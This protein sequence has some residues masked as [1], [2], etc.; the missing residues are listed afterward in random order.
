MLRLAPAPFSLFYRPQ[1]T[2][3]DESGVEIDSDFMPIVREVLGRRMPQVMERAAELQRRAEAAA[4][5]G[6]EQQQQQQEEGQSGAAEGQSG[7]AEGQSGAAE[8]QPGA[9]EGQPGP[10][11]N[12]KLD[13]ETLRMVSRVVMGRLDVVDL[14]GRNTA[15]ELAERVRGREGGG[16]GRGA[17]DAARRGGAPGWGGPGG[18]RRCGAGLP[19]RAMCMR[20]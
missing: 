11:D 4:A 19:L 8:G 2:P 1:S 14:V 16:A 17:H 9:A 12:I 10:P 3:L 15:E 13:D 5:A 18:A 7:A 20:L 6:G